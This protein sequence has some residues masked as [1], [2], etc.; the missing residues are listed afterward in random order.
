MTKI[1]KQSNN[2]AH[3]FDSNRYGIDQHKEEERRET[4]QITLRA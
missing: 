4:K 2:V 3:M 1:E